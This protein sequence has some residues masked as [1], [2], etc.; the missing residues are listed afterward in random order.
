M[1]PMP[2]PALIHR[3]VRLAGM[4]G[5]IPGPFTTPESVVAAIGRKLS[6]GGWAHEKSLAP[7]L[8]AF[9][10]LGTAIVVS[11]GDEQLGTVLER[12]A[13]LCANKAFEAVL[14]VTPNVRLVL[15]EEV[16]GKPVRRAF[17]EGG[18]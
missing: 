14:V 16:G 11:P 5:R 18:W 4:I 12:V 2:S 9:T 7:G 10:V 15:P 17:A 8:Y 3:L 13:T 6:T 1:V